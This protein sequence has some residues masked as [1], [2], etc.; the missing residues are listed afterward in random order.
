VYL[1][2]NPE[3]PASFLLWGEPGYNAEFVNVLSE[4]EQHFREKHWTNTKFEVF[5]N[6]KK[7]YKGF[8]WDG[9]EVRFE[10]DNNYFRVYHRMLEQAIPLNSPV[11]FVMRADTSWTAAQQFREL[12]GVI[13]FWV[14]GE[15]ELAWH[16][17]AIPRLKQHGDI[18]WTYGG[19]PAVQKVSAEITLNPLRS[20]ING[21]EGFVRWQTVDPGPDP[22]FHLTGGDLTLVYPG[23]R[24][25]IAG[26]VPS[27]R[28]KLQRNCLQDLALLNAL[29]TRDSRKALE[30]QVVRRFNDTQI[31]DWSN[32]HAQLPAKPILDW[33]NADF[34][35]AL[36]P[37][38]ARFANLDPGAW[39]RVRDF[40]LERAGSIQ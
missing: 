26:P 3:W 28:L 19:T 33:N 20:W 34:A 30:E 13:N 2:I 35:D 36:K 9:D 38:E 23:E 24:F 18:I 6:H 8:P 25:N 17:D 12:E 40:I 27:I 37:Y 4:M 5:F 32:A 21:V 15:G 14:V 31:A 16:P 1:P 29:C 10:R 39:L 11:R 22:W 7:R